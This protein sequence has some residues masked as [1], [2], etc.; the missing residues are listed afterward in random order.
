MDD[1]SRSA[2][3]KKTVAEA[4]TSAA[5]GKTSARASS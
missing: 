4:T 1:T 3:V 2:K 5:G